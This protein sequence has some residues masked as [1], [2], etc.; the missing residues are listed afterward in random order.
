MDQQYLSNSFIVKK[1]N[2]ENIYWNYKL[3]ADHLH[4]KDYI[5]LAKSL[6][7]DKSIF[8]SFESSVHSLKYKRP[9]GLSEFNISHKAIPN[10]IYFNLFAED[11]LNN[12]LK[13]ELIIDKLHNDTIFIASNYSKIKYV[14]DALGNSFS[15]IKFYGL[16]NN[17]VD[18][19][20]NGFHLSAKNLI[21]KHKSAICIENS[22]ETGYIQGNFLFALLSGT[23]PIIKAS[24]SV[25]KNILL[26]ECYL[27][28]SD[29]C[30]MSTLER[31]K[32]IDIKS[33]YILSG[34]EIFTNLAKEY[35]QFIS[36]MSLVDV[37]RAIKESQNFRDKIFQL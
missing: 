37:Q 9:Y 5:K 23:V 25:L 15:N 3:F 22:E 16:F 12:F 35:L 13:K 4:S 26:P 20:Q 7:Y 1:L 36:G 11:Y 33:E 14:Q 6:L 34:K 30:K 32:I 19:A 21:E 17:R 8:L 27:R 18:D 10:C 2:N 24:E 29:Y 28:F 31:N